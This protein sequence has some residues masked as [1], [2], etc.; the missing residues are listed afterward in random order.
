MANHLINGEIVPE[1]INDGGLVQ[2]EIAYQAENPTTLTL[3]FDGTAFEVA[4]CVIPLPRSQ[5]GLV[6]PRVRITRRGVAGRCEITFR[7]FDEARADAVE[8]V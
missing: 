5:A 6:R 4:P 1:E 7:L 3:D 2:L 8:V